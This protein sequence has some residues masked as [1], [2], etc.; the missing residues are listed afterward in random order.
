MS[1]TIRCV[2]IF[3]MLVLGLSGALWAS[4]TVTVAVGGDVPF[5]KERTP[6][7]ELSGYE[8]DIIRAVA[9]E[10]GFTVRIVE[11]PWKSIYDGLNA[12]KYDAV[13]AQANITPGRKDRFEMSEPYFSAAQLLVVPAA[14]AN[15]PPSGRNIGVFRLSKAAD[16]L[17]RSGSN[18][19][20]YTVQ[21]TEQA[22]KDLKKGSIDGILCDSPVAIAHVREKSSRLSISSACPFDPQ[23]TQE[24]YGIVCR[25]GNTELMGLINKG[26]RAVKSKNLDSAIAMKWFKGTIIAADA[27]DASGGLFASEIFT[28]AQNSP[29]PPKK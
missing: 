7:G 6:K 15:E 17:R 28:G 23:E 19:T 12:G 5:M 22:F 26:L 16:S 20:Y 11:A 3:S 24:E 1:R 21:E 14:R 27:K 25:K 9:E 8:I 2:I 10:A 4:S 13:I 18:L 29:V